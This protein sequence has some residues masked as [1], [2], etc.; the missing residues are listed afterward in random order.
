MNPDIQSG[1]FGRILQLKSERQL[2]ADE[3]YYLLKHH[4]VPDKNYSFSIYSIVITIGNFR[5]NGLRIIMAL[6]TLVDDGGYC[7]FCAVWKL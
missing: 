6:F 4:F 3:K 1:D 7:K 2:T 5:E